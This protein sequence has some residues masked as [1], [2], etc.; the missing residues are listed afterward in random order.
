M[1]VQLF[2]NPQVLLDLYEIQVVRCIGLSTIL[3]RPPYLGIDERSTYASR[4]VS[5][6]LRYR[7]SNEQRTR[8]NGDAWIGED[9]LCHATTRQLY[10][11]CSDETNPI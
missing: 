6:L 7:S 9:M 5:T 1:E 4:A 10:S 2:H 8:E 3:P 11:K